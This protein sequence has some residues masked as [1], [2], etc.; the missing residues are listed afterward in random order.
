MMRIARVYRQ[1]LG[2]WYYYVVRVLPFRNLKIARNA[3]DGSR[4]REERDESCLVRIGGRPERAVLWLL[5]LCSLYVSRN[6]Y[7]LPRSP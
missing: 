2:P 3:I 4:V 5:N 7:D 6:S 1:R